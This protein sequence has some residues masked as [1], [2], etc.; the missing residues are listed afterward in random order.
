MIELEE[1]DTFSSP[2]EFRRFE[3][4]LEEGI[5]SGELQQVATDPGYH[6][7]EIYGGR[8]FRLVRDGTVWRLVEPDPPFSGTFERVIQSNGSDTN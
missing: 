1:I 7:G 3:R 2:G 6:E 8:W 4:F 5:A